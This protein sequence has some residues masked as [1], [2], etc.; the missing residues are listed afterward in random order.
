VTLPTGRPVGVLNPERVAAQEHVLLALITDRPGLR[1]FE[2]AAS[3]TEPASATATRLSRLMD[4]GEIERTAHRWFI[5]GTAPDDANARA[6][7]R[8][9]A[10]VEGHA[11]HT[12]RQLGRDRRLDWR[13]A[14]ERPRARAK[15]CAARRRDEKDR[16]GIG[17]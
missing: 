1:A 6:V 11:G 8:R 15:A 13:L 12:W 5:A 16:A 4:R 3:V 10:P 2:I 7:D 9:R 14:I 17:G